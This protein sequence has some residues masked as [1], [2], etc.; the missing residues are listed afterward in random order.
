MRKPIITVLGHVD[1]G[2]TLLLDAIRGTGVAERE[3]GKITQHIGATE[4]PIEDIKRLSSEIIDMFGFRLS[5]SGLLFIDTPGHEAFTNLRKRGGS[6]ADLA[7]L[8][9]DIK[10]GIQPQTTE[11]IEILKAFKVPFVIAANK[12]DM[13]QGYESREGSV[14]LNLAKQDTETQN[15]VEQKIYELAGEMWKH[16]FACERFDRVNDFTKQIPVIPVSAKKKEGIPEVLLFLAGLS[17]KYLEKNL[18]LE[19]AGPGKGTILEVKQEKGLGQTIDVILY[20]GTIR[21]GDEIAFATFG[22]TARAR[23]R[24]LLQ[25]KPLD[26]MRDPKERFKSMKEISAAAGIK[27]A[28]PGLENAVAG[29]PV[30]VVKTGKEEDEIRKEIESLKIESESIGP[31]VKADTLGSLEAVVKM[32]DAKGI[33]PRSANAGEVTRR[34]I[35]EAHSAGEKDRLK[36]VVLAF[37][38][39]PNEAGEKAAKE[40]GVRVFQEKVIYNLIERYWKWVEEEKEKEKKCALE[41][42]AWPARIR[43][44]QGCVFRNCNPAIV[45]VRV[46]GGKLTPGATVFKENGMTGKIKNIQ[47]KGEAMGEAKQGEEVAVSIED[48]NIGRNLFEGDE[49]LTRLTKDEIERAKANIE[50]LSEE[51][52]E[53][54]SEITEKQKKLKK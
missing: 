54:L 36:G 10:Q 48:A 24:A 39:K 31:V 8:V 23:I 46:L 16:G 33:K 5:I 9:I 53:L 17:Q 22:G 40:F 44:M 27:I 25:P 20:D 13:I 47:D 21:T 28:A 11:S 2:K 7:V 15:T 4:V 3:A 1:H 18:R 35:I 12:I 43:V 29:S 45:G 32:L 50:C 52:K 38:T 14:T 34:D 42:M 30:L 41:S 37:N 51:E 49:L 6:I 26:E 19:V